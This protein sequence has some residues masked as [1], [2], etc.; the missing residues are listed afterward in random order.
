M[1]ALDQLG[2]TE[3]EMNLLKHQASLS[4]DDIRKNE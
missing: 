3:M 4:T 2:M 1:G